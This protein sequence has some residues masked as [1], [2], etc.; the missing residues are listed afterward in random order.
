[1]SPLDSP[2]LLA[3]QLAYPAEDASPRQYIDQRTRA[4]KFE[5][6][7]DDLHLTSTSSGPEVFASPIE[8]PATASPSSSSSSTF[9]VFARDTTHTESSAP[10]AWTPDFKAGEMAVDNFSLLNP[11]DVGHPGPDFSDN[12][13]MDFNIYENFTFHHIS[14]D[15]LATLA[16]QYM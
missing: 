5:P 9:P 6:T 13:G 12:A 14:D 8:S 4:I 16:D 10:S 2:E 3:L 7:S 1:M 15:T 11:Y